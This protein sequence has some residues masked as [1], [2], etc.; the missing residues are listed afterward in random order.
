[1]Y[2]KLYRWEALLQNHMKHS[3][4]FYLLIVI[5]SI[6][7]SQD[8]S[9]FISE[10]NLDSLVLT[11]R[12]LSGEDSTFVNGNKVLIKSRSNYLPGGGNDL[13]AD[14]IKERLLRYN[15]EVQEQIFN[16]NGR[17]IIAAQTGINHPESIYIICAH[18][19]AVPYYGADDNASGVSVVLEAARILSDQCFDYTIIYAL[20][21]NEEDGMVGSKHYAQIASSNSYNIAGVINIDGIGYD[22]NDDRKFEIHTNNRPTSLAIKDE[23]I[24]TI[25][26]YS[27]S[28]IPVVINPNQLQSDHTSF[29][30]NDYGA[31][32]IIHLY[33]GGDNNPYY[34]TNGDRIYLF[35]LQY[36]NELS[37]L[38]IGTL[39][40][41]AKLHP[42]LWTGKTS[43][44]WTASTNWQGN[45]APKNSPVGTITD[46]LIINKVSEGN[47]YPAFNNITIGNSNE[48][49]KGSITISPGAHATITNGLTII[50]GLGTLTLQSGSEGDGMLLYDANGQ[51]GDATVELYLTGALVSVSPRVGRFHYFVPPVA[52]Q[53][54]GSTIE[55][56]I[57]NLDVNN[58]NGDLLLFDESKSLSSKTQGWQYFDGYGNPST[59]SFTTLTPDRGYNIYLT[60]NDT[61]VFKGKLNAQQHTFSLSYT[62]GNAGAGWNL[63][64]NPYSC[65]YDLNGVAGI[66]SVVDGI[67]NTVYYTNEGDY[68]YWNVFTGSGSSQGYSDI[69][70][71]M[72]GF[73][74]KVS[75]SSMSL[76]FPT[77]SKT[78]EAADSRSIHKGTSLSSDKGFTVRKVK[79]V[80]SSGSGS[81]ETLALLFDDATD[82]YNEH[83]DAYKLFG[84]STTTPLIYSKLNGVDYFMKAVAGPDFSPVAV[85][86]EVVLRESGSHT[87]NITE[88]ENLQGLSVLLKHGPVEVPLGPGS[89]YTFES[90]PG[91]FNDFSLV[92]ENIA[93]MNDLQS[94]KTWY[95]K[96]YLYINYAS[97]TQSAKSRLVIYDFN[98]RQVYNNNNLYIV[99][100]R[101][102]QIP[103]NLENGFYITDI[104]IDN[105]HYKSKIVVY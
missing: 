69:I 2:K 49:I 71:P 14:Y 17:N 6:T 46:D 78:I 98:G 30:D 37:K 70:P 51:S 62:T 50:P 60:G 29:L 82:S 25:N 4:L 42:Y 11:V 5:S 75:K 72:T 102:I 64:G 32:A 97:V 103:L 76:T 12:D 55:D 68:G 26:I 80:L 48:S 94:L 36:F 93:E 16:G 7:Q 104:E 58:F 47:Y 81:D 44:N 38:C 77:S 19:D 91:T 28:L 105:I 89:N 100:E 73:F 24:N 79:L 84:S 90:E 83:Y 43:T 33:I 95:S 18:Y 10:T 15:L 96:N 74:I 22:S 21:D 88:F 99:P 9:Y 20:W 34:H 92:F 13:A 45:V 65:N 61:V 39:A 66:G 63:V 41:L 87:I 1:M 35:N 54:I 67:A 3:L 23:L 85:P 31:A 86:L 53:T 57:T 52:T 101:T 8:I 27:L 40:S 59:T 56:V